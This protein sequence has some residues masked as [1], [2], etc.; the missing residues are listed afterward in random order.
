MWNSPV[1]KACKKHQKNYT[2]VDANQIKNFVNLYLDN[3]KIRLHFNQNDILPPSSQEEF[4]N[5]KE[6]FQKAFQ[7][8]YAST[9][10]TDEEKRE[11]A[12]FIFME[13]KGE[14]STIPG[15]PVKG[16][17]DPVVPN[18]L[19]GEAAGGSR[20]KKSQKGGRWLYSFK[21]RKKKRK[22][23]KKKR[24]RTKKKTKKRRKKRRR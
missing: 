15:G 19:M 8:E 11:I 22:R 21:S 5:I 3:N 24:K 16:K 13:Q 2:G 12:P 23:T 7:M 20:R 18:S 6:E 9:N 4:N 14:I 10:M 1:Y 17:E